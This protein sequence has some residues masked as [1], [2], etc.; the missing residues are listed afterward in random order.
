MEISKKYFIFEFSKRFYEIIKRFRKFL[1]FIL[2]L[3]FIIFLY[4]FSFNFFNINY[5]Y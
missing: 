2:S 4:R 3:C 1:D 5:D